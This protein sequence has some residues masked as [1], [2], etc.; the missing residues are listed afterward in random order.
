MT[1]QTQSPSATAP[2]ALV[3]LAAGKGT[4]MKSDLHKV[5]HPVAGRPMLLHLMASAAQL[6]PAHQVVVAGHGRDQLEKALGGSATIAVQE[7]QLGTGHAVQQAQD[8]LAGFAG[9]VLILYGDVPFVRAQTMQAM[10]DRLH[11]ADAPAVVVLGFRPD[12]ALQYGRVIAEGDRV[13]KMVEHKDASEAE[14]ACTLCNSGLMAVKGSDLF[15]LLAQV[16]NDNAQGEYYLTDIVNVANAAGKT[17][18]V[19]VTDDPD[20]VAGINSRAELAQAEGRWQ[21][22]RR[23]AAMADGASL[24]A[25][26]TVWFSHDTVLGRDVTVEQNVVFGP[27]VTVANNVVIHAFCHLEGCTVESGVSVGPFARLRPGATLEQN[28]RVGNFVEVKNARLGAGAKANHLT[29]LGDADVGAG[30][31]IGAGTITCNY[32]GYFKYRTV[33][34]ERAFIGSNSALI[35]PVRIG[36]DAI[37]AAGSAVSRDVS[38]GELRLVR[39]E[40]LVKP[41]WADRFH[42]A[43]K[44]KKA[45][46]KK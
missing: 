16:G 21:Q 41:G 31:N 24:V 36:A 11:A 44:K 14:R 17:C 45:E 8:A 22:R 13:V 40:Q 33:I 25:P 18:A 30:A 3:I 28:S 9:D 19:V 46:G 4:R 12:D 5:L 29:Y 2:L 20:E 43:M 39:A 7:P 37:V 26:E 10:L 1:T 42:D 34:G 32:D 27:G 6:A 23:L 15:A 38:D 35:A